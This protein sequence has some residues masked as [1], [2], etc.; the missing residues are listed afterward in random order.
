MSAG[1]ACGVGGLARRPKPGSALSPEATQAQRWSA[2][3]LVIGALALVCSLA[4]SWLVG[5]VLGVAAGAVVMLGMR[6]WLS[7]GS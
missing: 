3:V 4:G 1:V 5:L 7:R 6:L 2:A